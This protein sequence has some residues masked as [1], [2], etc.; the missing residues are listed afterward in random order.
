MLIIAGPQEMVA[1]LMAT[2]AVLSKTLRS[3][4]DAPQIASP[5]WY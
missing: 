3:L 4:F 2:I 1:A 5:P